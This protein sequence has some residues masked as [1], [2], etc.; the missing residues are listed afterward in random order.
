M[1]NKNIT[2]I[3][4]LQ[5]SLTLQLNQLQCRYSKLL[6]IRLDLYYNTS[7]K[8][9]C[10]QELAYDDI[11]ALLK[12]LSH[13]PA[14][15]IVGYAIAVEYNQKEAIHFHALFYINGQRRTKYYPIYQT[16]E[17]L[18]MENTQGNGLVHDCQR[19]T[20]KI[21]A[22]KM[23]NYYD[24]EAYQIL[25]YAISYLA[26]AEQKSLFSTNYREALLISA[27]PPPS[28]RGR[29]RRYPPVYKA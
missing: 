5:D 18:W 15:D 1:Q 19:G 3:P 13:D 17:K 4:E 14:L 25:L 9:S 6:P 22:L 12:R 29:P 27:V 16:I 24:E 26:K 21:N 28:E 11:H 7:S 2:L 10:H 23:L 8:R 20:Y